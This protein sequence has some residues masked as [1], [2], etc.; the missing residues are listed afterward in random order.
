MMVSIWNGRGGLSE[1][2]IAMATPD[3]HEAKDITVHVRRCSLRFKLLAESNNS[4]HTDIGQIKSI[5][6]G[7]GGY[8]V[9]VSQPAQS[10]IGT[11]LRFFT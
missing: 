5:L 7:V 1:A 6:I 9:M 11:L 8:L 10:V 2:E 4:L 3:E